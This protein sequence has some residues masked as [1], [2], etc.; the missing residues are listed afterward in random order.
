MNGTAP[1]ADRSDAACTFSA[2]AAAGRLRLQ[3]CAACRHYC[4]PAREA[5]PR[6][7]S[8]DLRWVEVPGGGVLLTDTTLHTSFS[9]YFQARL[10]WRIG[11]VAMD[12]GPVV[13]AHLHGAVTDQSRVEL[14]ARTD[15]SGQ[16]VLIAVD[17]SGSDGRANTLMNDPQLNSL[18]C[19]PRERTVL[20]T[21]FGSAAGR[22]I[23]EALVRAGAKTVYAGVAGDAHET[24]AGIETVALDPADAASVSELASAI[25]PSL[26]IVIHPAGLVRPGG[27][28]A[29][30][31]TAAIQELEAN[32]L[33]LLR[34][35]RAFG[36]RLRERGAAGS[37]AGTGALRAWVNVLSVYALCGACGFGTSAASQAAA[38]SLSQALR[39]E[40]AGSGVKVVDVLC[41]PPDDAA[42]ATVPPPR[43]APAQVARAVVDALQQGIERL[44][45]G[46]VAEDLLLRFEQGPMTL[47]REAMRK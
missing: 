21:D 22:A 24:V 7:W 45:V 33:G 16:G 10:P 11:N 43:V 9:P 39:A 15:A 32:Y 41:G 34:V 37:G 28:I 47:E 35:A 23:A 30:D 29:G 1:P 27:P 8:A 42:N 3:R 31:D 38:W 6:C 13:V 19:D 14:L 20:V 36:P 12:A 40:L 4:Y 44:A 17:E 2:A 26:D 46:P 18:T 5:C 25:G